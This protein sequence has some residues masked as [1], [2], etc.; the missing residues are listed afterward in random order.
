M[1]CNRTEKL[2]NKNI[3]VNFNPYSNVFIIKLYFSL[4]R[5]VNTSFRNSTKPVKKTRGIANKNKLESSGIFRY[6]L[7]GLYITN[8]KIHIPRLKINLSL[9][10]AFITDLKFFV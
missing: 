2:K 6:A 10:E 4:W 5:P 8:N 7:R 3:K 1:F 9:T